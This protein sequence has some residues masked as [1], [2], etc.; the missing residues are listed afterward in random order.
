MHLGVRIPSIASAACGIPE[1]DKSQI[2]DEAGGLKASCFSYYAQFLSANAHDNL[3]DRYANIKQPRHSLWHMSKSCLL[4]P[5]DST[6]RYRRATTNKTKETNKSL[7][8]CWSRQPGDNYFGGILRGAPLLAHTWAK[9]PRLHVT[10][11]ACSDTA[12]NPLTKNVTALYH[13]KGG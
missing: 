13:G 4:L 7:L 2:K 9:S 1:S 12:R 5:P 11:F 10:L 8:R 6:S 3:N